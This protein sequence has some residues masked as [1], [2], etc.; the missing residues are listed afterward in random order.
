MR[1]KEG[2]AG[3]PLTPE[4]PRTKT[5]LFKVA[6]SSHCSKVSVYLEGS[7]GLKSQDTLGPRRLC[8]DQPLSSSGEHLRI[9]HDAD[10]L[11]LFHSGDRRHG[12]VCFFISM[13]KSELGVS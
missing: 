12:E 6:N 1:L 9:P 3:L 10:N 13:G 11:S 2:Q 5:L 4:E 7:F 8:G